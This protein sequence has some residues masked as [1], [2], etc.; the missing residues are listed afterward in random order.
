VRTGLINILRIKP[1]FKPSWLGPIPKTI[2]KPC[3]IPSSGKVKVKFTLEPAH[4]D[5]RGHRDIALLF[6]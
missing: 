5:Q 4:E 1:S 2:L 3:D 6:L